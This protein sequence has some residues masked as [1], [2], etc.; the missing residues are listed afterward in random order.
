MINDLFKNQSKL[1]WALHL[2]G[3]FAWGFFYK[4]GLTRAFS[5]DLPPKYWFYVTIIS[6][7]AILLS[8][9]LRY[10][11]RFLWS[12]PIWQQALGFQQTIELH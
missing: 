4:Y 9:G 8:L 11:Y 6:V 5:K 10:L 7:I 12:R 3:W 2:G 1:F